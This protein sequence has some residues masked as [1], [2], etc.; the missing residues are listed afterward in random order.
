[1]RMDEEKSGE[2]GTRTYHRRRRHDPVQDEL[3]GGGGREGEGGPGGGVE[4]PGDVLGDGGPGGQRGRERTGDVVGR[5]RRHAPGAGQELQRVPRR[6]RRAEREVPVAAAA[7]PPGPGGARVG[8]GGSLDGCL[9]R[10]RAVV[11]RVGL[12]ARGGCGG[13]WRVARGSGGCFW[14]AGGAFYSESVRP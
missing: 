13:E 10:V 8:H 11:S 3:R 14:E 6:L 12:T 9:L 7:R 2:G 1:M 4:L 5:G